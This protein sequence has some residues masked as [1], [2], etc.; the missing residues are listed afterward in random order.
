MIPIRFDF[1]PESQ[2]VRKKRDA[3]DFKSRVGEFPRP[4]LLPLSFVGVARNVSG[5]HKV[6]SIP[7]DWLVVTSLIVTRFVARVHTRSSEV[8]GVATGP[9]SPAAE[10][11]ESLP[12]LSK[13]CSAG[14]Q[15][16]HCPA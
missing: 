3:A 10:T 16:A 6:G 9:Y 11:S 12:H 5:D 2:V 13:G 14:R 1:V 7:P 15:V 8:T 4:Q